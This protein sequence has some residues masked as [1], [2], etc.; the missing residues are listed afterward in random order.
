MKPIKKVV[1]IGGGFAGL[2]AMY[3]LSDDAF[4]FE[5]TLVDKRTY[6][7]ERPVLPE[8]AI[9]GKAPEKTHIEIA[10]QCR[11]HDAAFAL[12]EVTRIDTDARRVEL[13]TGEALAYDYLIIASGA[14]KDY[15]AVEGY[16]DYG[17]SVCDEEEARRLYKRLESFE[18]GRIVAGAAPSHIGTRVLAPA[19]STPCEGPVGEVL[20][21]LAHRCKEKGIRERCTLSAFSP[22]SV[23]FEDV[24]ERVRRSVLPVF[25]KEGIEV[26]TNKHLTRIEADR[27][28][29]DDGTSLPC[30]LAVVI[31]P[32]RAPAFIETS[33]LGDDAGWVPTDTA[34]RHLDIPDIYA[35]GDVN[36]LTQPKLG[37]IAVH[38]AD[39][40]VSDILRR[41]GLGEET[42][43][44]RPEIFC[45]MDT[46]GAEGVLIFSDVLYGGTHDLAW[47]SVLAKAMKIGFDE[48][49]FFTHGHMP[50]DFAVK[51]LE[52]LL[53]KA[54]EHTA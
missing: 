25:E 45:I 23:F 46:G 15:D 49:Y 30:D 28:V 13:D 38:Q 9:E 14:T 33:G 43:P 47:R 11:K 52:E 41:E 32:Y 29:F 27:V 16:R 54:A 7:V 18:G 34:M 10:P 1:I 39:I 2:R 24:G 8:V 21:M 50:P 36:A 44:Y 26:Q 22:G 17:F 42:L 5:I 37:H 31:P 35:I 53:K 20:L 12:G 40:A 51:A 3:R 19:L 48:E 6:A 4:H